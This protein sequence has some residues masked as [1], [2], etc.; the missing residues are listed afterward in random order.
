MRIKCR[1]IYNG[2]EQKG[3]N[4]YFEI[5]LKDNILRVKYFVLEL[6][7]EDGDSDNPVYKAKEVFAKDIDL[8]QLTLP[9][10]YG[11]YFIAGKKDLFL[12]TNQRISR[13]GLYIF[14]DT[15]KLHS[16]EQ[17]LSVYKS[18]SEVLVIVPDIPVL[19]AEGV[20]GYT[21][22]KTTDAIVADF[23]EYQRN[24]DLME[25]QRKNL[26][27]LDPN[28]SLSGSEAQL[29]L[30]TMILLLF[31]QKFPTETE[32][33]LQDFPALTDFID[34]YSETNVLTLKPIGESLETM[35]KE[36]NSIRRSL[37]EYYEKTK[38]EI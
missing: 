3:F 4:E 38:Q 29:D 20:V 1:R 5:V 18:G 25:A 36:K 9:K 37:N 26:V 14:Q 24:I 30:L 16:T 34:I 6:S 19:E 12:A 10:S 13:D 33:L 15:Y 2:S 23:P 32:Q 8:E 31:M 17:V 11:A 7:G 28:N 35:R 27:N 21:E 22:T